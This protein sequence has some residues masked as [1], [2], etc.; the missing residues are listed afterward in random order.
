MTA[1]IL[2]VD[3]HSSSRIAVATVLAEYDFA[4]VCVENG[5]EALARPSIPSGVLWSVKATTSSLA[6]ALA[7]HALQS[8]AARS[9][10]GLKSPEAGECVWRSMRHQREPGQT[11]D[12]LIGAAYFTSTATVALPCCSTARATIY[13]AQERAWRRRARRPV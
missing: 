5:Q 7:T 12:V 2:V 1:R 8:L 4:C 6:R 11:Q 10:S 9:A 3:D 13:S